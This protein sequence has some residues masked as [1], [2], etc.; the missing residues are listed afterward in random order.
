MMEAYE[1]I[2]YHAITPDMNIECISR[3]SAGKDN[4]N[5]KLI[6]SLQ[7]SKKGIMGTSPIIVFGDD[8]R[9]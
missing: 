6:H 5:E 1:L 2:L 8:I 4:K 3:E 9:Q 7:C